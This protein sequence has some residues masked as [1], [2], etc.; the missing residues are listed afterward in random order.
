MAVKIR[1]TRGG[2]KKRPYYRL[3]AADARAPRDGKFIEKLGSYS[4]LLAKDN[5]E[6]FTVKK[7]R[8]EHWLSVGAQPT[9]RVAK[10]LKNVGVAIATQNKKVSAP[11][12][13][14]AEKKAS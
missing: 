5:A 11:K 9:E 2:T 12:K 7:E 4:P 3:V 14:P 10:L 1:L 8:V 6:R 13:K